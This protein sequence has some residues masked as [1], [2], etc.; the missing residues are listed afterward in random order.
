MNVGFI[1]LGT[2]GGCMATSILKAGHTLIVN[3]L[4][5]EVAKPLLDGG[6]SW[7]GL[8]SQY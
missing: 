6:A 2:M 8:S 5:S 1:G 7:S 3:D 4:R